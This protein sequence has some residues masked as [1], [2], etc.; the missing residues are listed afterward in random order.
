MPTSSL[1]GV[2]DV[3]TLWYEN[4]GYSIPSLRSLWGRIAKESRSGAG[5]SLY[6]PGLSRIEGLDMGG[7]RIQSI[8]QLPNNAPGS[9][10]SQKDYLVTGEH[11]IIFLES[12]LPREPA[13]QLFTNDSADTSAIDHSL[14]ERG[15][16][17]I[18]GLDRMLDNMKEDEDVF[19]SG[20]LNG[21]SRT[22]KVGFAN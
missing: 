8:S 4:V 10:S 5:G 11:R 17:D 7:E 9:Q 18:E 15:E 16:L 14:L 19:M 3:V 2:E 22:R 20:A 6:G 13:R 1:A 12:R 21:T